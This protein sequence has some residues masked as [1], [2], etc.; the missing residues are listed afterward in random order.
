MK[1]EGK[2]GFFLSLPAGINEDES[3]PSW[4]RVEVRY[5]VPLQ[6]VT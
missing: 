5:T 1:R 4:D 2:G 6:K 3:D